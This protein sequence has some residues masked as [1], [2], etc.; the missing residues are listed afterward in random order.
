VKV[1]LTLWIGLHLKLMALYDPRCTSSPKL[2]HVCLYRQH[3]ESKARPS[4]YHE[5]EG[6][7]K[8][9]KEARAT[10]KLQGLA[11]FLDGL[12]FK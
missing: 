12:H 3:I 11:D 4:G 10:L 6:L 5:Q 2:A 7:R 1:A 9:E 8:E